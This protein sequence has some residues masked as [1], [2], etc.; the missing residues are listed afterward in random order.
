MTIKINVTKLFEHREP[1]DCS[2]SVANLGDQAGRLTWQ[3][4]T[5]C[6]ENYQSWLESP[7]PDALDDILADA[8]E[9]GAWDDEELNDWSVDDCLAYLVQCIAADLRLLGS[10][11]LSLD[12]C[13]ETY[14][15]TD[16][17]KMPEY[18][19]ANYYISGCGKYLMAEWGHH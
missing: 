5:E 19:I 14:Q 11:D 16:W 6:A 12:E 3:C 10:D 15:N 9:T 1:W 2:N 13:F 17:D 7:L 18:P 4:A 8:R